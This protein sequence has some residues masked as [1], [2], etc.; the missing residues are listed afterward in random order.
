MGSWR[1]MA[2]S[3]GETLEGTEGTIASAL[4]SALDSA[5]DRDRQ[6]RP[7]LRKSQGLCTGNLTGAGKS[8]DSRKEKKASR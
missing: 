5:P 8:R 7:A 6:A 2:G 1:N 3:M 4:D